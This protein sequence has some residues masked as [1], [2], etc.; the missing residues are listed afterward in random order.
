MNKERMIQLADFLESLDKSRFDLRSYFAERLYDEEGFPI[1]NDEDRPDQ[2]MINAKAFFKNEDAYSCN[3]TACVAGWAIT[4]FKDV[5]QQEYNAGV[6][7]SEQ[8]TFRYPFSPGY[9]LDVARYI[10]GLEKHEAYQIF[11]ADA[12][13]LWSR[14]ANY[15]DLEISDDE[16][17]VQYWSDI[18]PKHAAEMLRMLVNEEIS[19]LNEKEWGSFTP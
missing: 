16:F 6:Y 5:I 2:H 7:N 18:H 9:E 10:L 13:S 4:K 8:L 15:F 17:G 3:T 12:P 14:F 1:M 19:F 11:F